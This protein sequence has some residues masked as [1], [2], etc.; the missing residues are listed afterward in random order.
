MKSKLLF[1]TVFFLSVLYAQTVTDTLVMPYDSLMDDRVSAD[2][3]VDWEEQEYPGSFRDPSTGIT[4]SWGYDDN[5]IYIALEAKGKG[6]LAIGFGSPMMDGANMFIGYYTDDSVVLVN[7]IGKGR[8]HTGAKGND[9]L[10]DEWDIDYD[11]ETNTTTIEFIY[12]LNWAGLKG[13]AI[14]GLSLGETYDLILAR[15]PKSVSFSAKHAQKS[16]RI[17]RLA[18][19]PE[20]EKI[21]PKQEK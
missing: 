16:R 4:V 19:K 20:L 1:I 15:N 14:S 7:H 9:S 17:F 2:G 13:S 21:K 12:P 18:P 6:W 10:L 3:Y 11:D 5:F 8:T